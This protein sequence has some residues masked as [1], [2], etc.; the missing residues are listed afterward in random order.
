MTPQ[1]AEILG[2]KALAWMASDSE[3]MGVFLATTGVA[4]SD[5]GIRS[6]DP[7]FL[8]SVLDFLMTSDANIV[9]FAESEQISPE[10]IAEA[11]AALPG[12]EVMHWT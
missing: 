2:L 11:R 1:D 10:K 9:E 5:L 4:A 6:G 3:I 8:G 12:G 7:E